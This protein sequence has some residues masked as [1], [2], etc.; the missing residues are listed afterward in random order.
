MD[1]KITWAWDL[2]EKQFVSLINAN[3]CFEPP[4]IKID[5]R[6]FQLQDGKI[7]EYHDDLLDELKKHFGD[8]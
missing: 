1:D 6:F 3:D 8:K 5:I 7:E 4:K 2:D